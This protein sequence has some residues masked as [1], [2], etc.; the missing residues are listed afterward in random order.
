[1]T[2][3]DRYLR[4]KAISE[5]VREGVPL[6]EVC[7]L[8]QVTDSYARKCCQEFGVRISQHK[9]HLSTT[10]YEIISELQNTDRTL[11][12][13]ADTHQVSRQWVWEVLQQARNSGIKFTNRIYQPWSNW[14][15][16]E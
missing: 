7:N 14:E 15:G 8:H 4:R 5:Q 2:H 12:Q 10:T 11:S 13:I 9:Q 16:D 3:H 6:S 1:M